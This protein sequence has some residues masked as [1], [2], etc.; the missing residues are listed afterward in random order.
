MGYSNQKLR[1]SRTFTTAQQKRLIRN[2]LLF[3][4][5]LA[6]V[7]YIYLRFFVFE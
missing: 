7:V 3:L 2:L 5:S 4:I 1:K 6:L